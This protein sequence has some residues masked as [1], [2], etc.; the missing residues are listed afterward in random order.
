MNERLILIT[1]G[2]GP[3]ECCWVVAKV[4]S[5]F[6]S[7]LKTF[8]ATTEVIQKQA[9]SES[10]TI[11]SVVIHVEDK[12]DLDSFL[13][14]WLGTIQWVGKSTFRKH[15]KRKNWFVGLMEL[16]DV[17]L[18]LTLMKCESTPCEVLEKGGQH[19]QSQLSSSSHASSY[20][21]L[22]PWLRINDHNY[23]IKKLRLQGCA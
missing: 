14:D 7:A 20:K 19:K 11:Q 22:L 15:H 8:G 17:D 12:P 2:H 18:K 3:A 21:G 1:S 5:H 23:R 6:L 9:G 10:R 13:K 4:L 16:K